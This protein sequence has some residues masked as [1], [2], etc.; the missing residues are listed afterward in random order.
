MKR[1]TRRKSDQSAGKG[2]TRISTTIT[3]ET[4][5]ELRRLAAA[6]SL[7]RT[8][9]ARECITDAVARG[10]TIGR[11]VSHAGKVI[12]YAAHAP[13]NPTARAAEEPG[14]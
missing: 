9:M 10:L 13:A 4:D 7:T 1:T 11:H 3:L 8:A 14:A 2:R 5:A 12:D 6:S